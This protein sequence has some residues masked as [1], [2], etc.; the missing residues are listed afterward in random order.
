MVVVF[1]E[2]FIL[3]RKPVGQDIVGGLDVEGLFNLGVGRKDEVREDGDGYQQR[4]AYVCGP[5]VSNA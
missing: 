2:P 3:P 4:Q 1:P 5:G